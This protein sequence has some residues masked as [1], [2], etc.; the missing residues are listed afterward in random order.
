M[1]IFPYIKTLDGIAAVVMHKQLTGKERYQDDKY[2]II[3][4]I[5]SYDEKLASDVVRNVKTRSEGNRFI[6]NN[7]L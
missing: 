3:E 5:M 2:E 4:A 7:N 6:R 1:N